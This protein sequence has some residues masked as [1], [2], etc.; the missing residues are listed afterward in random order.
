MVLLV[1]LLAIARLLTR[2]RAVLLVVALAP[3]ASA[4]VALATC[5]ATA[6]P[7]LVLNLPATCLVSSAT[8][9]TVTATRG[10]FSDLATIP[11][12]PASVTR[13]L[14]VF[15]VCSRDCPMKASAG[16]ADYSGKQCNNCSQYGHIRYAVIDLLDRIG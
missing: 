11:P 2:A 1:T 8:H 4:V 16:D 14:H 9:A 6:L 7:S 5:L 10:A 12:I 13:L 15:V 3:S